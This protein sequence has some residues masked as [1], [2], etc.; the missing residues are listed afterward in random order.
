MS[1]VK[2]LAKSVVKNALETV[3]E[4]VKPVA[5]TVS[6]QKL[7][8]QALG[9]PVSPKNEFSDYLK[10]I[11]PDITPEEFKKRQEIAA[12]QDKQGIDEI[13]KTL[14]TTPEH[15]KLPPKPPELRPAEKRDQEEM[16]KK[17]KLA[18]QPVETFQAPDSKKTGP[19]ARMHKGSGS[20]FEQFKPSKKG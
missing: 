18:E 9:T 6:P 2:N 4:S 3:A 20:T 1:T 15:M 13:R 17:Q 10:N 5:E 16:E 7:I 8:E 14:T 19:K 11:S 12:I